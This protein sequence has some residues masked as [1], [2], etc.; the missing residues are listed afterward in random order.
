MA[1]LTIM[2]KL[3]EADLP[4]VPVDPKGIPSRAWERVSHWT[5]VITHEVF[6]PQNEEEELIDKFTG[7][8]RQGFM[9]VK[10][11]EGRMLL[12]NQR[13]LFEPNM[14][15][16]WLTTPLEI[17]LSAIRAVVPKNSM[18]VVPNGVLIQCLSGDEHHFVCL[19]RKQIISK[20]EEL[21]D[22]GRRE[23]T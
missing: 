19:A 17:P 2:Q 10:S 21:L 22:H 9:G 14:I 12:T 20:I 15:T 4:P 13:L 6:Q 18:G 3:S 5:D 7:T 23:L 8:L 1:A 11:S 16:G